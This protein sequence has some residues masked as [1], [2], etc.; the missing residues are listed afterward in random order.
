MTD[1][2]QY[3]CMI[4]QQSP[5]GYSYAIVCPSCILAYFGFPCTHHEANKAM[6][7]PVRISWVIKII[8]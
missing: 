3:I 8:L 5:E 6:S 2:R 1:K 7:V 4:L